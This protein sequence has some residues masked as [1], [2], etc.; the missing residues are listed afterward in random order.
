M[1]RDNIM[2]FLASQVNPEGGKD[3]KISTL[4]DHYG[5]GSQHIRQKFPTHNVQSSSLSA[6]ISALS[7]RITHSLLGSP[8]VAM[9]LKLHEILTCWSVFGARTTVLR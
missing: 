2:R 8:A 9:A 3:L 7:G 6:N 4:K 1:A 5:R